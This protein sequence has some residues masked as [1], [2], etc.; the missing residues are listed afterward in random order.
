M[1]RKLSCGSASNDVEQ[2]RSRLIDKELRAD[3][4]RYRSTYRLLLLGTTTY[5]S[6]RTLRTRDRSALRHFGT[7]AEVSR[8]RTDLGPMS[9]AHTSCHLTCCRLRN[10]V[11]VMFTV[12]FMGPEHQ[13]LNKLCYT[14]DGPRDALPIEILSVAATVGAYDL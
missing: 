2:H 10:D 13:R 1:L 8:V 14:T 9:V 6:N 7:G 12:V 3:R 11:G 4:K 5:L